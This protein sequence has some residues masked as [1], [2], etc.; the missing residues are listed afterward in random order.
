[1]VIMRVWVALT[2]VLVA[3]AGCSEPPKL[4]PQEEKIVTQTTDQVMAPSPQ[5]T[6]RYRTYRWLTP[7]ETVDRRLGWDPTMSGGTR[8]EVEQAIDDQLAQRGYREA[9]PADFVVAFNDTYIDRSR[10]D[11][12]GPLADAYPF[13]PMDTTAV[14]GGVPQGVSMYSG[15]E[16]YRTPEEGFVVA[17]Y[18]AKTGKLLWRGS[19]REHFRTMQ[20]KQTDEGIEIAINHAMSTLPT[21]LAP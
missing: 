19:G 10:Q 21:P 2:I 5:V 1:M 7:E 4:T 18:D 3:A 13:D 12:A 6:G 8:Y 14:A 20:G 11:P 15:M 16:L 9:Q 17:F